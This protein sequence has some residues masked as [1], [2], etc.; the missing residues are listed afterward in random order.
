LSPEKSGRRPRVVHVEEAEWL[1]PGM[2]R[3]VFGG[4]GFEGFDAGEF[5]DHYVK[6]QLPPAGADYAPPFDPVELRE[7]KSREQWPRTRTFTVRAWDHKER[8]LTVDFVVHGD[9]GIAGPWAAGAK[10]GDRV[11]LLGPGGAY[12]PDP[13]MTTH[14]LVGDESALPAIAAALERIPAGRTALVVAQVRAPGHVLALETDAELELNWL[15][16]HDDD[17]VLDAVGALDFPPDAT[18]AFV[19]GEASMVRAV[20][21]YLLVERGLPLDRLSA[22]GYWKRGR[23]DEGW[24][25]EKPEWK[26]LAEEDLASAGH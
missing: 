26:R 13:D 11:Q 19:H 5:T 6:L 7:S 2:V 16:G 4:D 23:T 10:P 15:L 9:A 8:R 12:A 14:V 24:R 1:T 3:L 17:A 21:R 25:E 20:R 22:S 18:Q